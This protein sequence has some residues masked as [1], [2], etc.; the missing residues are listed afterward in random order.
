M[1]IQIIIALLLI[2]LTLILI[3][4]VLKKTVRGK[5]C[6]MPN[7]EPSTRTDPEEAARRLAELIRCRTTAPPSASGDQEPADYSEFKKIR[8]LLKQF[9]PLTHQTLTRE[10]VNSHSMLYHWPG[11]NDEKPLLLMAHYDVVPA[12]ESGWEQP[13]FGGIINNGIIWGRGALDTKVTV[14]AIFETVEALLAAG[15][16]PDQDIYLAFGHDEETMGH[17]APAIVEVLQNRGVRPDMVLDEGG[18]IV[19]NVFPGV[20]KPIAV[21]GLAEKGVADLEVV[22]QGRGGHSST[23]GR[24]NPLAMLGRV[25]LQVEKNPF[26]ADIPPE[27]REMFNILGGHMPFHYRIVFANL[28][29]FKPLLL[30]LLP[31]I[32]RELNALCR[33]T[34][35]F[36]IARAGQ[37]SNVIPEQV[38]AVA[39]LRLAASD[40]LAGVLQYITDQAMAATIKA[41]QDEE[42]LQVKVNLLGGHDASPS[43]SVN[44]SAY[45][46]LVDT[47]ETV[48]KDTIVTP[49]IMLGASDSRH[50][51]AISDNVLR[52][53]PIHLSKEEL[54]SIH[55]HNERITVEKLGRVIQFYLSL[56]TRPY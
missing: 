29:C 14:C 28:W 15:F 24:N 23:P 48:F 8:Q 53:S 16:K 4:A 18:A 33:T 41:R 54:R 11:R 10:L 26:K 31:L 36:T 34:C 35:V 43:T 40:T 39:N 49:Y 45:R 47:V 3:R 42:P 30:K 38:R 5:S 37:A 17:G 50:Y 32:S 19:D 21:V 12:D 7:F 22:L 13:P 52:F 55:G 25:I 2:W 44:S 9:Y 46:K 20:K 56:V 51:C 1:F 27:V 6:P